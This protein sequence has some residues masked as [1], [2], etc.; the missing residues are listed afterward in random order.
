[1]EGNLEFTYR[2]DSWTTDKL[3]TIG[4]RGELR[5]KELPSDIEIIDWNTDEK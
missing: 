1:M 2:G 3:S 4:D 5:F